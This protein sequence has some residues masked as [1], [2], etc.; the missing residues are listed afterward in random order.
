MK[1]PASFQP[2]APEAPGQAWVEERTRLAVGRNTT[3]SGKLVFQEPVRIEGTFR[4]EVVAADLVVIAREATIE[5]RI[6]APRVLILGKFSGDIEGKG[7]VVLGPASR[8]TGSIEA[9]R[10][11]VCEGAYLEGTVRMPQKDPDQA[12]STDPQQRG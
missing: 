6:R 1:Y 9:S 8:I 4:G 7:R 10:L 3:V 11:T 12:G 5:G 2:D